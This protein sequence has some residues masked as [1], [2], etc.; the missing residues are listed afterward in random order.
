[1]KALSSDLL[2]YRG[3]VGLIVAPIIFFVFIKLILVNNFSETAIHIIYAGLAFF[4][5]IQWY[6]TLKTKKVMSSGH[7]LFLKT[8]FT[9]KTIE[10]PIRM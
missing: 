3:L 9:N 2:Y 6:K 10:V 8:Y 1:M 5:L 7:S 4:I